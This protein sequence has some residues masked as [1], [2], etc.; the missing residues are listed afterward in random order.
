MSDPAFITAVLLA[1]ITGTL[2]GISIGLWL[3]DKLI[4]RQ[5]DRS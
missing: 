5:Q 3:S 2:N 4:R 1:H